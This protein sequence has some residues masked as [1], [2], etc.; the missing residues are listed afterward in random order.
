VGTPAGAPTT[1][2]AAAD[3]ADVDPAAGPGAP[4]RP[5]ARRV[6]AVL[7]PAACG[8]GR[9]VATCGVVRIDPALPGAPSGPLPIGPLRP[10]AGSVPPLPLDLTVAG[11]PAT[12]F[13]GSG[14]TPPASLLMLVDG[15]GPRC[16]SAVAAV[17]ASDGN[18]YVV[19]LGRLE[20]PVERPG[21]VEEERYRRR[22]VGATTPIA[23]AAIDRSR[24]PQTANRLEVRFYVPY[25]ADELFVFGP[26]E[27]AGDG[28][29]IR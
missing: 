18:V 2:V 13:A 23:A 20:I 17:P 14:C 3:V 25:A 21:T 9:A 8:A 5:P 15:V 28:F 16:T 7:D 29:I 1:L 12:P 19:D 11:A 6:Y 22:Q 27:P 26:G 10:P 4:F 24:P